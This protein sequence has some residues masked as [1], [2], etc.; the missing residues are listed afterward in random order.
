MASILVVGGVLEDLSLT[1]PARVQRGHLVLPARE[2]LLATNI[3]RTF[4][5]GAISLSLALARARHRVTTVA[6]VGDDER[7]RAAARA[8][9]DAGVRAAFAASTTPTGTSAILHAERS[10][11]HWTIEDRGAND[12]LSWRDLR[13]YLQRA[14]DALVLSHLSGGA[15]ALLPEVARALSEQTEL[16]W[17]PGTTQIDRGVG[18]ARPL[19]KKTSLLVLNRR[20]L[21]A[22]SS[23]PALLAAGVRTVVV[24]DGRRGATAYHRAEKMLRSVH[25][26]SLAKKTVD[27]V[28][29]G[30]AFLSGLADAWLR[31]HDVERALVAGARSAAAAIAYPLAVRRPKSLR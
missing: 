6:A 3:A 10:T 4:G 18:A 9:R 19:L 2:K 12:R 30:D 31:T 5:G 24:T 17:N 26:K 8:L 22:W 25:V 13:P 28:G 1:V 7:G 20:E 16:I 27:T 29:A 14:P 15:H 21:E 23:V 11:E